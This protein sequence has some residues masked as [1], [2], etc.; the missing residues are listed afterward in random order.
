MKNTR[1]YEYSIRAAG[2]H[3]ILLQQ[4]MREKPKSWMVSILL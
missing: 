2:N 1:Q 3:N 4:D